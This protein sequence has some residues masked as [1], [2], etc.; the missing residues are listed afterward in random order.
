MLEEELREV[1]LGLRGSAAPST[2]DRVGDQVGAGA[3]NV[4]VGG[5]E[6]VNLC[7]NNYLGLA[8]HPD[9]IAA[10]EGLKTSGATASRR[11]ASSAA[12]RTIHRQLENADREVLRQGR[13]HPLHLVLRRQ[14][15]AV[16]DAA[17]AERTRSSPTS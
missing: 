2:K 3:R 13:H 6:V 9:V 12:R 1:A 4:R 5:R 14:R 8:N 17:G 7:A 15:R 11:C 16:R 10:R